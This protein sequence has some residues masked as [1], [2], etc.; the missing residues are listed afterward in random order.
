MGSVSTRL[1]STRIRI[2]QEKGEGILRRSNK[3]NTVRCFAIDFGNGQVINIEGQAEQGTG[4][5]KK[6]TS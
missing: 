5:T 4:C 1:K 2:S 6:R 3:A